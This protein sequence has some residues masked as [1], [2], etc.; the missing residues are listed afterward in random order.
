M[1]LA[2]HCAGTYSKA[3]GS[4]GSDGGRIR[5]SPGEADWGANAGLGVAR[6]ALEPIKVSS[7]LIICKIVN[8]AGSC[9]CNSCVCSYD[10]IEMSNE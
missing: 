5:F 7:Y 6:D 4:G 2:W 3:D 8:R 10:E 9:V 1:R